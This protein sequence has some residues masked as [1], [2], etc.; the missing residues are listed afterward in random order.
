MN[1]HR[2]A[3]IAFFAIL[4]I[5]FGSTADADEIVFKNGDR[6]SGK[7]DTMPKDG[8]LKFTA[9]MLQPIKIDLATVQSITTTDPVEI[10]FS[11][12]T[13]IK[14]RIGPAEGGRFSIAEGEGVVEAQSF[15]FS[16]IAAINPPKDEIKWTGSLSA[17]ATMTRGNTDTNSGSVNINAVRRAE[18]DRIRFD[19]GYAAG[20]QRDPDSG[21]FSTSERNLFAA[22]QYDY[23]FTEKVYGWGRTRAEKDAIANLDLRLIAG[24]GGGYQW[25]EN[26]NVAFSTE[27]GLAWLSENFSDETDDD[28]AL[29][30]RAA[31]NYANQLS[32]NLRFFNDVEWYPSIENSDD[33]F[34]T[35]RA[36]FQASLTEQMFAEFRVEIDWDS[37]PADTAERTDVLYGLGVGWRF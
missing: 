35:G 12:G 7:L 21:D 2:P 19:A 31:Y 3:P 32:E 36:G 10:H 14:R 23:Y 11:D 25:I 28:D 4:G 16:E 6:L 18:I 20:R 26:E 24:A 1:V 9:D 34:V 33:H 37:S 17:N 22:L 15:A 30:L 5:L 27:L 13:V 29:T 8:S